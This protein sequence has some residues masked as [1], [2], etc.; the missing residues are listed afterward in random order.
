[1]SIHVALRHA[2]TYRFDRPVSLSPHSI[3]LRP[4]PHCRAQV[5]GYSLRVSPQPHF[6]NWLQ[7]PQSNHVARLVFPEKATEF[8]VEVDL[9][10]EMAVY[11]PFDFSWRKKRKPIPSPMIPSWCMNWPPSGRFCPRQAGSGSMSPR[12]TRNTA[13]KRRPRERSI[14]WWR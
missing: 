6:L 12:C 10:V 14:S 9:V 11:N 3:R 5:L 7:D 4:A 13:K 2:T 1:M 8:R